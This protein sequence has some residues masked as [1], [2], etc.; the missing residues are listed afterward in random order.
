MSG[1]TRIHQY[2]T[3]SGK[4]NYKIS[5]VV[6]LGCGMFEYPPGSMDVR[7]GLSKENF[8]LSRIVTFKAP[9]EAIRAFNNLLQA[10]IAEVHMPIVYIVNA[11]QIKSMS[12]YCELFTC[13]TP[14]HVRFIIFNTLDHSHV[15]N[16][17]SVLD[18]Q[19]IIFVSMHILSH[20]PNI[21]QQIICLKSGVIFFHHAS[22]VIHPLSH[23]NA[24]SIP[25]SITATYTY[26]V[27]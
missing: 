17:N 21:M 5:C 6:S 4:R 25:I 14:I 15:A 9:S 19:Y 7:K 22:P 24:H 20:S 12:H 13:S 11:P 23:T 18:T 10:L 1:L 16:F 26:Q 8:T 3:D 2:Y 27:F